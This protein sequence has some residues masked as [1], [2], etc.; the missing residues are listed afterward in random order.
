MVISIEQLISLDLDIEIFMCIILWYIGIIEHEFL[1]IYHY[2]HILTIFSGVI[3]YTRS[4]MD[5]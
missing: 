3:S 2:K 4:Y 1:S 5:V